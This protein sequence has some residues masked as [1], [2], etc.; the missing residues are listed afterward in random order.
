[1]LRV[2]SIVFFQMILLRPGKKPQPNETM[3]EFTDASLSLSVEKVCMITSSNGNIYRV[4]GPL[5]VEFTGH[6]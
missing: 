6:R 5:C 1:M 4:T 3:E 2:V